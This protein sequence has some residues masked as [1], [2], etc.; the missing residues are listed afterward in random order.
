MIVKI[1]NESVHHSDIWK[2]LTFIHLL[3]SGEKDL[4]SSSLKIKFKYKN[5][6][7]VLST[8]MDYLKPTPLAMSDTVEP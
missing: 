4:E 6:F 1:Y 2:L 7:S 8:F 5:S 3:C